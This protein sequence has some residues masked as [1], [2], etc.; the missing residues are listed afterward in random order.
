MGSIFR[1]PIATEYLN[2]VCTY[3]LLDGI[4][5]VTWLCYNNNIWPRKRLGRTFNVSIMRALHWHACHQLIHQVTGSKT[6]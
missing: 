1:G 2:E 4:E 3:Y 6:F 5:T